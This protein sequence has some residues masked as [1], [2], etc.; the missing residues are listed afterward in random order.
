MNLADFINQPFLQYI[1]NEPR[2]TVS[3][4]EKIP[5]DIN[6]IINRNIIRGATFQDGNEPLTDLPTLLETLPGA[7]NAAYNLNQAL[8][9]FVILDIEPSCPQELKERLNRLSAIYREASMS[10][11]GIHLVLPAPVGTQYE[12]I[13]LSKP[14]VKSPDKFYEILL[15]HYVTFTGNYLPE[16]QGPLFTQEDFIQLFCELASH[17]PDTRY[18]DYEMQD[19]PDEKDIPHFDLI[20]DILNDFTYKK[21][22][23][24]FADEK[25]PTGDA[26]SYEFGMTGFYNIRLKS[27][28]DGPIFRSHDYTLEERMVILCHVLKANLEY[29]EKHDTVRDGLPWLMFTCKRVLTTV[30]KN[31]K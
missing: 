29:R 26:S 21:T 17:A 1:K 2:W 19:I 16:P 13:R 25:H 30:P 22:P 11:N 23:R 12:N 14:A 18:A 6:A 8:D 20:V 5:L 24:D 9:D 4:N 10:G 28:L 31:N 15:T 3:N 7:T 27:I